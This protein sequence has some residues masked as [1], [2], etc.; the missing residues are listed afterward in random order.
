[1]VG[2][3]DNMLLIVQLLLLLA[4][5]GRTDGYH[6]YS[7]DECITSSEDLKDA[8]YIR[9]Y[10]FNKEAYIRFNS[11]VGKHVGYTDYGVHNA[12]SFNRGPQLQQERGELER[13]CKPNLRIDF[14]G[15]LSKSVKPKVKLSSEQEASGDHPALLMCS[16]YGFY[17]R[18]IEVYWLR[19]GIKETSDVISTEEMADGNWYYQVHSH[20]EHT[21]KSGER[22][23]CVVEH[24]SS[25]K[26]MIY[27]WD[28]SVKESDKNKI[29]IGTSGLVLG[30]VL[31][32]AGFI[33][34]K[35]KSSGRI[36]VPS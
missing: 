16:A 29:A 11:T 25:D 10:Y 19:D 32:A 2:A 31:F 22:I 33:Y 35:K 20:L 23:S 15:T 26:P 34:Y 13:Y 4:L 24:V 30:I 6:H 5:T 8:E 27:H 9:T 28:S 18:A 21:P 1:V 14:S 3:K 12:E 36:L 7:I 17:P